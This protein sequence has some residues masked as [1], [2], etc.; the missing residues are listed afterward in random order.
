MGAVFGVVAAIG[1]LLFTAIATYYDAAV[2]ADELA[3]SRDDADREERAQAKLVSFWVEQS[4][5]VDYVNVHIA[6]RSPD[7]I[8]NFSM[9]GPLTYWLNDKTKHQDD[10]ILKIGDLAPCTEIVYREHDLILWTVKYGPDM[11]VTQT[12]WEPREATF[13]D[14]GGSNWRRDKT[15]LRMGSSVDLNLSEA[16]DKHISFGLVNSGQK[17]KR[18]AACGDSV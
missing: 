16:K 13:T 9:S 15:S 11:R 10:V 6:N 12:F 4:S 3:Q 18:S 5:G 2:S 1:S 7:P 17:V 14:G 8:T